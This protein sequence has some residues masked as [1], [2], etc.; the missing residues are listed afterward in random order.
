MDQCVIAFDFES[1]G[2]IPSKNGFTQLGAVLFSITQGKV[3]DRFNHY[4]NMTG[5]EEEERCMTEFWNRDDMKARLAE[6][7][8]GCQNSS[9]SPHQVVAEFYQWCQRCVAEFPKT[10]LI[11]DCSA[12]D[13][14]LLKFFSPVDTMY[15]LPNKWAC[16]SVDV[17]DVYLGIARVP[18]TH[19]VVNGSAY[20]SCVA[21]LEKEYAQ[22]GLTLAPIDLQGVSH[23]HHPVNDAEVIARKWHY[24][25]TALANIA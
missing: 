10:Y 23:D 13:A 24:V 15:F 14:G 21:L 22:R 17:S 18:M 1:F 6:T 9:L 7:R 5:Y 20:K 8:L 4:A 12:Y 25:N 3:L 16:G 19:E 11:T 2:G